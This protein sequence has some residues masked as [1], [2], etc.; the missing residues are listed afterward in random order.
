MPSS[1]FPSR[2]ASRIWHLIL[3]ACMAVFLLA[4]M[5]R[6]PAALAAPAT[7]AGQAVQAITVVIDDSYPPYTF[8]DAAGQLQGIVKDH[9]ALWETYNGIHEIGRASCRERV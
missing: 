7:G 8:R 9:W 6:A 4:G 5:V 2:V 1:R 3:P